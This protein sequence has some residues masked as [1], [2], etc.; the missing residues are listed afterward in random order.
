MKMRCDYCRRS[1][2]HTYIGK[3]E[4]PKYTLELYNCNKCQS[5][6]TVKVGNGTMAGIVAIAVVAMV[7]IRSGQAGG[8]RQLNRLD[9]KKSD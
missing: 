4:F 3:Q 5:T 8:I 9:C 7:V 2:E 1:T 6:H